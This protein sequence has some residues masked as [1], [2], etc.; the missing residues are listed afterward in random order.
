[1]QVRGG[2]DGAG[3]EGLTAASTAEGRLVLELVPTGGGVR[4]PRARCA[5]TVSLGT[6]RRQ[7]LFLWVGLRWLGFVR[8]SYADVG[9]F[10]GVVIVGT[11]GEREG[12]WYVTRVLS[13]K[14]FCGFLYKFSGSQTSGIPSPP[15]QGK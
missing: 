12:V 5:D 13:H 2:R 10:V 14:V 8:A 7:G 3:E 11:E 9:W 6:G 15:R 1:M 4:G